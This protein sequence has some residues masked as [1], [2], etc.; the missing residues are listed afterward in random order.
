MGLDHHTE[1]SKRYSVARVILR[2]R[3]QS[4]KFMLIATEPPSVSTREI[5]KISRE[6]TEVTALNT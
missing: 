5:T 3:P 2:D 4:V 6:F 1:R